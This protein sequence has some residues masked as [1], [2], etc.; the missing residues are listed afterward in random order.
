[1]DAQIIQAG[2]FNQKSSDTERTQMLK[3]I[4]QSLAKE[5]GEDE[6]VPSAEEL[7]R[8]LARTEDEFDMFQ[9]MD[10]ERFEME[11]EQGHRRLLTQ[12]SELPDWVLQPE[13]KQAS[14]AED[15]LLLT[16]S[17]G[18]GRRK[19]ADVVY[20]DGLTDREWTAVVEQDGDILEA[21]RRKR[22]RTIDLSEDDRDVSNAT[23]GA[24]SAAGSRERSIDPGLSRDS[25]EL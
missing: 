6:D 5:E 3:Q 16:D 12:E 22:R 17:H 18:R 7:N 14:K 10:K 20:D 23:I 19:R 21:S 11:S 2:Q 1:M 4:L 25:S 8:M 9:D 15:E 13:L 24:S